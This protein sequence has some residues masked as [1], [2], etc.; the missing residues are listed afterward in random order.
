MLLNIVNCATPSCR[1][2]DYKYAFGGNSNAAALFKHHTDEHI[3]LGR[4]THNVVFDLYCTKNAK[5]IKLCLARF[6]DATLKTLDVGCY[7]VD[8][9]MTEIGTV[10]GGPTCIVSIAVQAALKEALRRLQGKAL[11]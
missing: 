11:F 8:E 4:Y 1:F 6:K 10:G 7:Y 9:H 3:F 5:N 2:F